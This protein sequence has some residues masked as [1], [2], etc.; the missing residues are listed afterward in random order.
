MIPDDVWGNIARLLKYAFIVM[1]LTLSMS[2]NVILQCNNDSS[3]NKI[4]GMLC[5][6]GFVIWAIQFVF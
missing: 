4:L 2:V 3:S 1:P 5:I 6:S